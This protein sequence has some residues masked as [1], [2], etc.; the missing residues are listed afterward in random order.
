ML[1]TEFTTKPSAKKIQVL[2]NSNSRESA[3]DQTISLKPITFLETDKNWG[4]FSN[5]SRHYFSKQVKAPSWF[6]IYH[7]NTSNYVF[8]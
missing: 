5:F 2:L 7:K 1:A 3:E 6:A 8:S 4:S